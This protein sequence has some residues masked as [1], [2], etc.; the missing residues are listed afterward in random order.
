MIFYAAAV[1][2][3]SVSVDVAVVSS[4]DVSSPLSFGSQATNTAA[5]STAAS[6]KAMNFLSMSDTPFHH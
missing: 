4:V 1:V 5:V 2:L 3:A 6:I